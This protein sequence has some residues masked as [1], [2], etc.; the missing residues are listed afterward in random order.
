MNLSF[1]VFWYFV[2]SHITYYYAYLYRTMIFYFNRL[3]SVL[4]FS[5]VTSFTNIL[6]PILT[7]LPSPWRRILFEKLIVSQRVK[8]TLLSLWNPEVHFRIHKSPPLDPILSQPNSVHHIDPHLPKIH[9]N[10]ILP[11]T[12][13]FFQWSLTFGLLLRSC[14]RISPSPRRF[15]TFRNTLLFCGEGLLSPRPIPKLEDHPLS[16]VRDCL[17][18]IFAA[19][20]FIKAWFRFISYFYI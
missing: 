18:N 17:F 16:A 5:L 2:K 12:P 8:N 3:Y 15:E 20:S 11:P 13:R 1:V 9:L 10:V 7:Y 14:Q 19:N 6:T 4:L